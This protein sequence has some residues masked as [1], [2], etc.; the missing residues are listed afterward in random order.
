MVLELHDVNF[1]AVN[2]H[3]VEL[4]EATPE[5]KEQ[6]T[7]GEKSIPN[8]QQVRIERRER[9]VP[10]AGR[11]VR[12]FG[13]MMEKKDIE[14]QRRMAA[15]QELKVAEKAGEHQVKVGTKIDVEKQKGAELRKLGAHCQEI[16]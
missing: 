14:S 1:G 15:D 13:P 12:R 4:E 16:A 10:A 11:D 5:D 9:A 7:A 2:Q 8:K 6:P 3:K